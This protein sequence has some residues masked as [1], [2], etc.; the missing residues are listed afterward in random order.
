MTVTRERSDGYL[1]TVASVNLVGNAPTA[2]TP[3]PARQGRMLLRAASLR[4][5]RHASRGSH[6][7]T[8]DPLSVVAAVR[9]DQSL[10][11]GSR[12]RLAIAGGAALCGYWAYGKLSNGYAYVQ[13]GAAATEQLFMQGLEGKVELEMTLRPFSSVGELRGSLT[14]VSPT[15]PWLPRNPP[16]PW[17]GTN[18]KEA[19]S[20]QSFSLI[21]HPPG[22]PRSRGD[23][24]RST[25]QREPVP[26]VRHVGVLPPVHL[27]A[28]GSF[29]SPGLSAV[30]QGLLGESLT[31][32]CTK[33]RGET[34]F[35]NPNPNPNLTPT[36]SL[37]LTLTLTPTRRDQVLPQGSLRGGGGC[38]VDAGRCLRGRSAGAQ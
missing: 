17:S 25:E 38:A 7:G 22:H 28:L 5:V 37:T 36:L 16:G 23:E 14:P 4:L 31:L 29:W 35:Y 32:C 27:S 15:S 11:S 26:T 13:L 12:V 18:S 1:V 30:C 2:A 3:K 8:A 19:R 6:S 21:S 20:H 34:Q 9:A 10:A 24:Q 33:S